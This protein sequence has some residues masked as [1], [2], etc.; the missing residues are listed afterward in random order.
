MGK[1]QNPKYNLTH[2]LQDLEEAQALGMAQS[3]G[4]RWIVVG[5]LEWDSSGM[6]QSDGWEGGVVMSQPGGSFSIQ[7]GPMMTGKRIWWWPCIHTLTSIVRPTSNDARYFETEI[8][9]LEWLLQQCVDFKEVQILSDL[10]NSALE[11]LQ[12]F[13]RINHM[14]IPSIYWGLNS[15]Q[16][17]VSCLL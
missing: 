4:P 7:Q 13:L 10:K 9:D 8:V 16:S 5:A 17:S 12:S 3:N 15:L 2:W 11:R 6:G 14:I 1:A